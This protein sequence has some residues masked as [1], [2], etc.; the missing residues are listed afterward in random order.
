MLLLFG[1]ILYIWPCI[2]T[3]QSMGVRQEELPGQLTV[4][5]AN[6]FLRRLLLFFPRAVAAKAAATAPV[7]P[8]RIAMSTFV[9][10]N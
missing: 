7:P 8:P 5:Q 2:Q 6:R 1:E 10:N 4:H 3:I 9:T